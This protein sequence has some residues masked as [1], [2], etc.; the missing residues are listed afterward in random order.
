MANVTPISN[1]LNVA[2]A[3][4][5]GDPPTTGATDG[6][7]AS[8]D[9]VDFS[10]THRNLILQKA[11]N[12]LAVRLIAL[13]GVQGASAMCEGIRAQQSITFA[14][15]G[16]S[17]NKDYI[18]QIALLKSDFN[19]FNLRDLNDL[20]QDLDPYLDAGYAIEGG[21]IYAFQRSAGVL[22]QLTSGTGTLYYIKSDRLD[23]ST[24][25]AL[26][27]NST[28]DTS[29]DATWH[30]FLIEYSA[31]RLAEAKSSGEWQEKAVV[32]KASADLILPPNKVASNG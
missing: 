20:R 30:N 22:S 12:E 11:Y 29:I 28:S 2:I 17:I 26:A 13:Y 1:A 24:G 14:S 10:A 5:L 19:E 25:S 23:T 4:H 18:M 31:Y 8:S 9:G 6:E 21:K 32:Y 15:G 3:T 16:T 27:V 7:T